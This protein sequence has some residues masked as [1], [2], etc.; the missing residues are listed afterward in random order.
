MRLQPTKGHSIAG[1]TMVEIAIALGV[2]AFALVA[3]IGV[4]PMG[5]NVQRENRED[6]V[7][8]QDGPYFLE[9]I[10][11]GAMPPDDVTNYVDSIEIIYANT[12]QAPYILSAPNVVYTTAD[13]SVSNIVGLLSLPKWTEVAGKGYVYRV[14]ARLRALTGPALEQTTARQD[15][16]FPYLLQTEIVKYNNYTNAN[17]DFSNAFTNNLYDVKITCRWPLYPNGKLGNGRKTFRGAASGTAKQ[18]D[19]LN[20]VPLWYFQPQAYKHPSPLV[21]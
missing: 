6:T 18:Q 2:I 5:M 19:F 21:P 20:S 12:N 17:A 16:A 10:R 11:S 8:N 15:M 14:Q 3:I 4:L 7:I 1:F 9:A 13:A